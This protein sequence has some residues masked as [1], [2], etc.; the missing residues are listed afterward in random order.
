MKLLKK[1]IFNGL[2]LTAT[3]VI[4]RLLTIAFNVYITDMIGAA[5]VGTFSLIMSVYTFAVTFATSGIY[6]SATRIVSQQLVRSSGEGVRSAMKRCM[7]YAVFFGV[8]G[9][10]ILYA[11]SDRI[12]VVWL[13]DVRTRSSLRI[14]ALSLPP[15]ALSNALSGYFSAVRRV[16]KNSVTVIA[17]QLLRIVLTAV[18]LSANA[19]K[20]LEAASVCIVTGI[21]FSE[22]L[23]FTVSFILYASDLKKVSTLAAPPSRGL[24]G[25][26]LRMALP[27]AVS[28]YVRSALVTL[29]H[30]LIP[31]GLLKHGAS[32]EEALSSY[33]VISGMVFPVIFFPMAFLSAF[34]GLIVPEVTRYKESG[35]D[36]AIE[37]VTGRILKMTVI[38]SVCIA[39][40][41][42][43]FSD[44]L[45]SAL[46]KNEEA[47]VYIRIFAL[48]IP[49]M[50]V[51][52][53][54]DAVLKGLG[55]QFASMRY[56]IIDAL[57]SVLLVF[58]LLPPFG[59]KGYIAAVYV[60]EIL[61]AVLSLSK[62]F[63]CVNVKVGIISSTAVTSACVASAAGVTSAL[64]RWF[65]ISYGEPVLTFTVGGV[66]ITVI[67]SAFLLTV[68]FISDDEKKWFMRIFSKREKNSDFFAKTS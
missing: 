18:L 51:D 24:T 48:L 15:L 67:Y 64:F 40:V 36:R 55:E 60:C 8:A 49:V 68:G 63:R 11:L 19:G 38:F 57:V 29:E 41:L 47:G 28:S 27:I 4:T 35:N 10:I 52:N 65:G 7:L 37:Y 26:L 43:C 50:Y 58:F 13:G 44:V 14:L 42:A 9:M 59:I 2:I 61:N 20:G 21:V 39:G 12:A 6:L 16:A 1:F 32:N 31:K 53:A 3:S 62:L 17:E 66:V 22:A 46:Y 5:G 54:T 33:G 23:S 56:N 45:A 30:L 34:T 25:E